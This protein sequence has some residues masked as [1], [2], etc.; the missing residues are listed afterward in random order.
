M[1]IRRRAT[2]ASTLI[3]PLTI[4][5]MMPGKASA[6]D[7]RH[8]GSMAYDAWAGYTVPIQSVYQFPAALVNQPGP[9]LPI[10]PLGWIY[11]PSGEH[12]VVHRY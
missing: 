3:L 1:R 8:D 4:L 10:A 2:I 12:R 11:I 5:A 7:H 6:G 9:Q